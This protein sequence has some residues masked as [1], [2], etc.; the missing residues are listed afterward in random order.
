MDGLRLLW[1][2][3]ENFFMSVK[4]SVFNTQRSGS[5]NQLNE[6]LNWFS[7]HRFLL[8]LGNWCVSGRLL[9]VLNLLDNFQFLFHLNHFFNPLNRRAQF[10]LS[11]LWCH[12]CRWFKVF[13]ILYL[14]LVMHFRLY[15]NLHILCLDTHFSLFNDLLYYLLFF[16]LLYLLIHDRLLSLR[17]IGLDNLDDLRLFLFL[18]FVFMLFILFVHDFMLDRGLLDLDV[19]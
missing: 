18:F 14:F 19:I 2:L 9:H 3:F 13:N 1:L 12:R 6:W 17:L 5:R 7:F 10:G 15:T 4:H 11:M 8:D 16:R